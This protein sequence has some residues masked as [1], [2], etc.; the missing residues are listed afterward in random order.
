[1]LSHFIIEEKYVYFSLLYVL[2]QG[3]WLGHAHNFPL[4]IAI[5]HGVPVAFLLVLVVMA[6]LLFAL[7]H[8]VLTISD[9]KIDCHG[10]AVFDR[11]WWGATLVLI[12]LHSVDMPFFD[13]RLNI[14]GWILLAGLR[15]MIIPLDPIQDDPSKLVGDAE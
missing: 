13:S 1:M 15:S 4:E 7:R 11:A 3:E 2:R 5:S 9:K 12:S 6:L 8:G 10:G 14:A